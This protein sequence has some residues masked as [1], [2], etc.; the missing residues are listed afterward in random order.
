[1]ERLF[2]GGKGKEHLF[3]LHLPVCLHMVERRLQSE[4]KIPQERAATQ[5][6]HD[7]H[8]H[9]VQLAQDVKID[10]RLLSEPEAVCLLRAINVMD[11][12]DSLPLEID[13]KPAFTGWRFSKPLDSPMSALPYLQNN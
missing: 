6:G 11:E 7:L 2:A 4:G 1:M 13:A 3:P 9:R 10:P 12:A 5:M 8:V